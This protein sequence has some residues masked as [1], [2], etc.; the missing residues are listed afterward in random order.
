MALDAY[1]VSISLLRALA[2][3]LKRLAATDPKLEDQTRRAAMS[4]SL[5]IA[6]ARERTGKDQRNR[7]RISLGSA[8]EVGAA[9]D[10]AVALGYIAD[11]DAA[12]AL[13]LLD[14][15]RAMTWRLSR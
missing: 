14:R 8:A 5:N 15:V 2:P 12:D 3:L 4:V 11:G 9:L 13:A 6:E 7:Y 1:I 10:V